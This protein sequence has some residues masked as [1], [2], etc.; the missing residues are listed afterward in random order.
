MGE[1]HIEPYWDPALDPKVRGN[2]ERLLGL[3]R[4]LAEMGIVVATRRKKAVCGLL[5]ARK[6]HDFLR[7]VVDG[8]QPNS[9]HRMPPHLAMASV[10]AL[11]AVNVEAAW[12]DRAVLYRMIVGCSSRPRSS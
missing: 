4:R 1:E 6:K 11:A 5:F 7:M 12:Q 10:E 3:L 8:R 2:R 9:F